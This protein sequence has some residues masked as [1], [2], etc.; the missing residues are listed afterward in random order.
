MDKATFI[1]SFDCEGKWGMADIID[2][3]INTS[4]T[5]QNLTAS[6]KSILTLLD[7][8]QI[9]GTFA[10]VAALT[11]SIDEFKDKRDWFAKSNVMIDKNQKWLKNF[12]ESAEGNNFNGWFHPSLLDLVINSHTRH[13]IATHGFTHLPLSENIIDQNCFKHEMD[14]VQ[15]IM[16]MKGLNART[17]IFPRNL[18][19][20]LN[21]LNDYN[22][23][24]YRDRLFKSGSIFLEKIKNIYHEINIFEKSQL[25]TLNSSQSSVESIK[26]PSGYFL[27]YKANIRKYIPYY[28]SVLRWESIIKDAIKH[29]G[30]VHLW[31]HPHNF[32]LGKSQ[33]KLFEGI[34][35]MVKE[36]V[37]CDK[38][39]V[40]SQEEFCTNSIERFYKQRS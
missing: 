32:I 30:V 21:L 8:Y 23:I 38:M 20:Y 35:K 11:M 16:T 4:I 14:R 28:L 27:N 22:I 39:K 33:Y 19:G 12:F 18:I 13:E 29:S 1:L 10:F 17:I 24:G 7:K 26:I 31:T 3:K 15:D 9:K 6:Y 36:A 40:M 5:N 2:D 34:L 25:F 37:D